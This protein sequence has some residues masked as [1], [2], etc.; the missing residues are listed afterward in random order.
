MWHLKLPQGLYMS[1]LM[2]KRTKWHVRPAKTRISWGI[3]PVW[4]QSSLPAWRN[5]G[6]LATHWAH[7]EDWSDWADAQADL[8]LRWAHNHFV[9]FHMS[10]LIY[11]CGL[12]ATQGTFRL[13]FLFKGIVGGME[14]VSQWPY[15]WQTDSP[16][17]MSNFKDVLSAFCL[18]SG[19]LKAY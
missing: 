8:S 15:Q 18:S 7:S 5:L 13:W 3:R 19:L 9:G 11:T 17:G 6:S 12:T 10:W 4:S 2:T 16:R 1:H 14:R